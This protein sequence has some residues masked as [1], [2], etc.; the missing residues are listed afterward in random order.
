[1]YADETRFA[2]YSLDNGD[3]RKF[4]T[5]N[6]PA[7]YGILMAISA[8]LALV[9]TARV[10]G[11]FSKKA[12]FA[13]AIVFI[14]IGMAYSGTRTATA[15]LVIGVAFYIL[16]TLDNW[17]TLAFAI[18]G[19]FAFLFLMF[20]PI[21]GNMT[22]N[23]MRSAFKFKQDASYE[24]RNVNRA[25]V[26][27]YIKSHPLGGG[28]MTTGVMSLKYNPGH[29]LAGFPP[30]SGLLKYALETG[31]VGLILL[32]TLYFII[33]QQGAHAFYRA[34]EPEHKAFILAALVGLFA[35][36]IAQYSQVAIGATPELFFFY[37]AIAI[38]VKLSKLENKEN[39]TI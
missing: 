24:V 32:C 1:L 27:P 15:I 6:D 4:S 37:P 30:D 5:L 8:L 16:L 17:K 25:S 10:P 20:A 36:I 29:P 13:I 7:E 19:L 31:W 9:V 35:N 12:K 23:R 22:I 33:L 39:Q 2:I 18:F 3:F 11:S 28:L 34:R 14:V 38:I 26:Q 21:Y